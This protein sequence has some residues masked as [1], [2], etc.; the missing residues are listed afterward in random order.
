MKPAIYKKY[1]LEYYHDGGLWNINI[2]AT[3]VDDARLRARQIYH[4]RVLGEVDME[5]PASFGLL[6]R[7]I[8]WCKNW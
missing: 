3:S 5:I 8:C 4:A 6:A 1:L 7:F 2:H